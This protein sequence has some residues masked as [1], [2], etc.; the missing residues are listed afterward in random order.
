[1]AVITYGY[2]CE[3]C[4]RQ[5]SVQR[6]VTG[7]VSGFAGTVLTTAPPVAMSDGSIRSGDA[8]PKAVLSA[9]EVSFQLW[10]IKAK[11]EAG[12][13]SGLWTG[14]HCPHCGAAQSWQYPK[15]TAVGKVFGE[16]VMFVFYLALLAVPALI[17]TLVLVLAVSDLDVAM[18]I[19]AGLWGL[20]VVGALV[21]S[22]RAGRRR[23]R[24]RAPRDP[25][26]PKPGEGNLPWVEWPDGTR[27]AGRTILPRQEPA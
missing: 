23:K 2:T 20:A 11:V 16:I 7:D 14:R 10:Q 15:E 5:D 9:A 27:T 13:Y 22:I 25:N 8:A 12:N 19:A 18:G 26:L 3:Q 17:V 1:M 21:L 4:G 24:E 6:D